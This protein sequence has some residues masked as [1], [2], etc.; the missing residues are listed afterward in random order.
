MFVDSV[1][2]DDA[3]LHTAA[4]KSITGKPGE[5]GT[6]TFDVTRPSVRAIS[7]LRR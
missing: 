3:T 5:K 4:V 2:T 6:V 7:I 1:V